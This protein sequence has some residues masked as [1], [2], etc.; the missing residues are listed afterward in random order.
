MLSELNKDLQ[1]LIRFSTMN[2]K[3]LSVEW[4]VYDRKED[5]PTSDAQLLDAA[6]EAVQHAYAPYSGFSVGAA[7][8]LEDGEVIKGN[9]QENAAYPSGLCAERI[10][11]FWAGANYPGKKI[12]AVAI[13]AF[14]QKVSTDHPITPCGACRQSM[15]EYE[16][17][18]G[19]NITIIMQGST[20]KIYRMEGVK[21]LLPLYFNED[22]LK[23]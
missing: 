11:F 7:L 15:L 4:E 3:V 14:S 12:K 18:Q 2:K 20:G 22:G 9:N 8:Q 1:K 21:N 19:E 23:S 5:L 17:N 10:A 16:M 13:T 6:F